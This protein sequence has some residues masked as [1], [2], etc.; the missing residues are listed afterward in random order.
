MHTFNLGL[1]FMNG[2]AICIIVCNSKEPINKPM[3]QMVAT[4][5]LNSAMKSEENLKGV[6]K[7]IMDGIETECGINTLLVNADVAC[8]V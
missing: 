5:Y 6:I 8:V 7:N 2:N 4:K 1:A 3:V